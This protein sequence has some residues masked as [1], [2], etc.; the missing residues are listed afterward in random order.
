MNVLSSILNQC[1][2]IIKLVTEW[3]DRLSCPLSSMVILLIVHAHDG[4]LSLVHQENTLLI[5]SPFSPFSF[6]V[7][8][9]TWNLYLKW[10]F[11][12]DQ[13]ENNIAIL[14][15]RKKIPFLSCFSMCAAKVSTQFCCSWVLRSELRSSYLH[16][17]PT[18]PSLK[19]H[20]AF[21]FFVFLKYDNDLKYRNILIRILDLANSRIYF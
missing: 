15:F 19:L 6:D 21:T 4:W 5:F 12:F 17:L 3:A 16:S 18:E 1:L 10:L 8:L 9:I 7:C 20:S 14:W 13:K 2:T 11:C